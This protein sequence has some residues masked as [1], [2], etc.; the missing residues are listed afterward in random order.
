MFA[1]VFGLCLP[2]VQLSTQGQEA[3]Q[4]LQ[5]LGHVLAEDWGLVLSLERATVRLGLK[6]V[7]DLVVRH[8]RRSLSDKRRPEVPVEEEDEGVKLALG[9]DA[10]ALDDLA[11]VGQLAGR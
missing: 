4:D 3:V 9:I 6:L 8:L 7:L 10:R 2:L 1:I 5:P 11:E